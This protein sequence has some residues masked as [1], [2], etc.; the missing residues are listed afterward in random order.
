M[1]VPPSWSAGTPGVDIVSDSALVMIL[2]QR[3]W[4]VTLSDPTQMLVEARLSFTVQEAPP[5]WGNDRNKCI[6]VTFPAFPK[7]GSSIS[8]SLVEKLPWY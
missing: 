3:T 6:N 2:D 5:G 8:V 1:R 7:V 4:T